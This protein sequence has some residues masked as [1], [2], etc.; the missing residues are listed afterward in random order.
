MSRNWSTAKCNRRKSSDTWYYI[1]I[2][3]T[4]CISFSSKSKATNVFPKH[5]LKSKAR[6]K[7]IQVRKKLLCHVIVKNYLCNVLCE[8]LIK[9][10]STSRR[11]IKEQ[12][13]QLT[14]LYFGR[15]VRSSHWR[16]S[17]RLAVLKNFA[18]STGNTCVESLF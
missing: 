16:F 13:P 9:F 3:A 4:L 12:T 2:C 15:T 11:E 14:L 10:E 6:D 8:F 17:I 7:S 18:I 1:V 5:I